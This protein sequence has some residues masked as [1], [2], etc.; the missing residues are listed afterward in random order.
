M[1][2]QAAWISRPRLVDVY[3]TMRTIRSFE[4]TLNDLSLAGRVPRSLHLYAGEEAVA[5]G[6]SIHL[7]D[8]TG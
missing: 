7:G 4:Q 6:V 2:Q 5:A 8:P 3:R 1:S